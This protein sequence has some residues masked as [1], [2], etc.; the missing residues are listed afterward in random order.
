MEIYSPKRGNAVSFKKNVLVA[1]VEKKDNE[2]NESRNTV[3]RMK[4]PQ[5]IVE[6]DEAPEPKRENRFFNYCFDV[7][8]KFFTEEEVV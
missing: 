5:V 6:N 1:D 7:F 3:T 4:K 2:E 8:K